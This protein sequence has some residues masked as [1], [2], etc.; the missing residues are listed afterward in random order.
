VHDEQ[1]ANLRE[2]TVLLADDQ[3]ATRVG[4]RRAIEP[5]ALRVVAEASSAAEAVAAACEQRPDVCMLAN[6]LPGGGIEAGR[7]I[8]Q[9]LPD[10]KIVLLTAVG[11]S[12]ELFEAL[13]AGVDGYLLMTTSPSRLPHVIRGVANG[14]AT[15][16]RELTAELI[17]GFRERPNRRHLSIPAVDGGVDLTA[18][19]FDVLEHLRKG[20]RTAEVARRLGISEITVRRHVS[21][22]LHKLGA[23]NRNSAIAMLEHEP[24]GE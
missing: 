24:R 10:T 11:R 14:E 9:S 19:E 22:I 20:E 5:Y 21:S 7:Q 16:P 3:A 12:E 13:R 6:R 18:R 8:K 2:I 4:I 17:K 15:V 23:P 1:Q